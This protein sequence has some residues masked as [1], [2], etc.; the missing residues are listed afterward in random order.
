MNVEHLCC[1]VITGIPEIYFFSFLFKGKMKQL[2]VSL[3][4]VILN[5]FQLSWYLIL[6]FPYTMCVSI[7]IFSFSF[8]TVSDHERIALGNEEG[9]FVVHVTKDGKSIRFILEK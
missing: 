8:L 3:H 4:F 9:L 6:V 5:W 2:I 7:I 1:L